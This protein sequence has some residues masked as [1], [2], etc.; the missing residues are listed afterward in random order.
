[1][2]QLQFTFTIKGTDDQKKNVLC[3]TSIGTSNGH[4]YA[5]PDE[6]QPVTQH[7]EIMAQP[8]FNKI[9]NSLTR[10]HQIKRVWIDLTE[11]LANAYLDEGGNLH[12]KGLFLEEILEKPEDRSQ[13]SEQPLMKMLEKLLEKSQIQSESTGKRAE[14]FMIG[15]FDGRNLDADQW[16]TSFEKECERFDISEDYKKIEILKSFMDKSAADWYSCTL[17]KLTIEASWEE[18]KRIFCKT[19]VS[20]GWSRIRYALSFRYQTGPLLDYAIKKRNFY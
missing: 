12:I 7:K 5:V 3:I 1:M 10:R 2:E 20:K 4:V 19:F 6:Y 17:L 9:K 8:I 16:I 14:Q 15:R 18:W 13:T 11:E